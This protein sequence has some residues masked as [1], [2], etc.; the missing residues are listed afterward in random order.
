MTQAERRT[1]LIQ[2][3]LEEQHRYRDLQIPSGE[4][5]QKSLLR[6][7]MN[8]RPP[9]PIGKDFLAVQDAYLREETVRKGVTDIAGLT[10]VEPGICLWQ[11]DITTL[12]C[13]AHRQRRQ[14][15]YDGLLCPLSRLY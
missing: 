15:R 13:G 12:K 1:F 7:L 5:E 3:L 10:P 9:K 14:Q 8:V 6:A 2:R 4:A 11:G